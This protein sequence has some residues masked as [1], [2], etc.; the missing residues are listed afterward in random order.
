MCYQNQEEFL[1]QCE[2][3][4]RDV[5]E[6][7]EDDISDGLYMKPGGYREYKDRLAQ[8]TSV[9]RFRTHSKLMVHACILC[10]GLTFVNGY[11]HNSTYH[12]WRC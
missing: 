11:I 12:V 8:L 5:F 4:Q 2:E 6:T 3:V 10:L 9:Y 7:L 1:R